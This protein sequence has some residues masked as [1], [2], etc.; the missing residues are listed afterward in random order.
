M[1]RILPFG[2]LTMTSLAEAPPD[3]AAAAPGIIAEA[4]DRLSAELARAIAKDGPAGALP[5]CSA[6]APRIAAEVGKARGVTLRR[7]TSKARNPKNTAD[8]TERQVLAG[9]AA[10]L[11]KKQ[12]PKPETRANPDGSVSF[13]APIVLANPLCLQC[14]GD[15][16]RDIAPGTL[17]AIH[18]LYPGDQATGFKIGDLRGVWR[19]TFPAK[20]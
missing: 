19:V 2:I 7:A 11:E 18:R 12:A 15:P 13:F 1:K 14:H 6:G 10:A 20:P 17:E 4:F 8:E 3:P 9:F 16:Q 5:V